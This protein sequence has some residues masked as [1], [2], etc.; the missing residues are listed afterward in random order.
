MRNST[1]LHLKAS[2]KTA[3]P[4]LM[5]WG[6]AEFSILKSSELKI[7]GSFERNQS[8]ARIDPVK[9]TPR[10]QQHID[11]NPSAAR[12]GPRGPNSR[13]RTGF[14]TSSCTGL[15]HPSPEDAT[16]STAIGWTI[17]KPSTNH[18]R[19]RDLPNDRDLAVS[20]A[21]RRFAQLRQP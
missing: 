16:G 14:P 4:A 8:L 1:N 10:Y 5:L 15:A 21:A 20:A 11:E 12:S 19:T 9:G 18:P 2:S 17:R 13:H 7:G 3:I 6:G